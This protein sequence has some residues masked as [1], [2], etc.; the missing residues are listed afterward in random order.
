M[1][2][3]YLPGNSRLW[4]TGGEA[5]KERFPE[6]LAG[7]QTASVPTRG[8]RCEITHGVWAGQRSLGSY[9][10][11]VPPGKGTVGPPVELGT[12]PGVGI[13]GITIQMLAVRETAC[14]PHS[15]FRRSGKLGARQTGDR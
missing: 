13:E 2:K 9:F 4:R 6:K 7:G 1:K 11:V 8:V 10:V 15:A 14:A 3:G 5:V 12:E